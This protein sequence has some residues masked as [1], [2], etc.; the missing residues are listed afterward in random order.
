MIVVDAGDSLRFVTQGDHAHF[1]ADLLSLCRLPE[2]ENHPRREALL[3]AVREHDNGWRELD[4]A[5][6]VEPATMTPHTFE[7]LP[8]DERRKLWSRGTRRLS[9][10][11]PQVALLITQ[12]ALALHQDLGGEATW[13]A[14][15]EEMS[16]FRADLLEE[17]DLTQDQLDRDHEY[18]RFADRCSLAVCTDRKEP[19]VGLGAQVVFAQ[20]SLQIDPLPLVGATS[21]S[22]RCRWLPKRP[23]ASDLDLGSELAAA[24]WQTFGVRVSAPR[25]R[26]HDT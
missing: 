9:E 15:L 20:G 8:G 22:I 5:P 2:L 24:R 14:W 18:L 23:Y 21:F 11:N 10:G 3:E 7:T 12:H 4:A 19:F 25:R 16:D 26:N 6:R 1:A 17:T 13:D